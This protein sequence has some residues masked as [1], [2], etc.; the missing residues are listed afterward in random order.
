MI[1]M[2]LGVFLETEGD[3]ASCSFAR[4]FC[5]VPSKRTQTYWHRHQKM[6]LS[7]A[8]FLL[9][10][11]PTVDLRSPRAAG[12]RRPALLSEMCES[13]RRPQPGPVAP[14]WAWQVHLSPPG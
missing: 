13:T 7:A 14:S 10:C 3:L 2:F 1:P 9:D 12:V 8:P 11:T 5:N 6:E 4:W